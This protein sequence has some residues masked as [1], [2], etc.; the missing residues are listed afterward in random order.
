MST[1]PRTCSYRVYGAPRPCTALVADRLPVAQQRRA[2]ALRQRHDQ[3]RRHLPSIQDY[4]A[5]RQTHFPGRERP[6]DLPAASTRSGTSA[7]QVF[8]TLGQITAPRARQATTRACQRDESSA[9][10]ASR[11]STTSTCGA[12]TAPSTS[13]S[14]RRQRSRATSRARH[15]RRRQPQAVAQRQAR[16]GGPAV[17][18]RVDRRER[19]GDG[20]RVR[21]DG[22]ATT[23]RSTRWARP[24]LQ[25]ERVHRAQGAEVDLRT[26]VGPNSG[27][28]LLDRADQSAGPTG[29]T[30]KVITATAALESGDWALDDTYDDTG[31]YC[32]P[33][34]QCLQNAGAPPTGRST[35]CRRSGSPTT[36]SSTTSACG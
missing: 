9:S 20:R 21:G 16:A 3:D 8:G 4:I 1:K 22:P 23:A 36:S 35:W 27:D 33:G 12:S 18:R 5:E 34:G 29:S 31:K 7:A 17:A 14:T 26:A 6:A 19:R 11:P 10:P 15:R 2:A 24:D 30:F 28:P 13:R 25:P 32:F